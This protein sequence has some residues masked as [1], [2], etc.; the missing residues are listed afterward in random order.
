MGALQW[1]RQWGA[2]EIGERRR[3]RGWGQRIAEYRDGHEQ[4][5]ARGFNRL[6]LAVVVERG[7]CVLQRHYVTRMSGGVGITR[8]HRL[9]H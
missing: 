3:Q 4:T 6:A 5:L 2:L 9:F 1:G 7:T 8:C